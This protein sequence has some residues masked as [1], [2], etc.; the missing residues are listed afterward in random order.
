MSAEAVGYVFRHSP[1]TGAAFQVHL[2]IA[3][4]V[5]DQ[6]ANELWMAT[7]TIAKKAR[8]ARQ[9][10]SEALAEI[11]S[12]GGL[13]VVEDHRRDRAGKPSRYRFLFPVVAVHYESRG[14]TRDDTPPEGV[15]P[16]TTPG[17]SPT[18]TR[19]VTTGDTNPREPKSTTDIGSPNGAKP[20][21]PKKRETQLPK[22]WAPN[23]GHRTRASQLGVGD[24]DHQADQ[25]KYHHEA[26]GSL[27]RSWDAAFHT[28][29][30][31]AP[32]FA[33]SLRAIEGGRD[34]DDP[35]ERLAAYGVTRAREPKA[36]WMN[37]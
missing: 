11:V 32:K 7:G 33:G 23:D 9:T 18:A 16:E 19:G 17:V 31:N 35:D 30:G 28:W 5:N 20:K 34:S 6:H 10:A 21:P 27:F 26:K 4:S 1:H 24:L 2:A 13:E 15:S 36:G 25:F 3:D 14:V 37:G 29:I 8:V 22:G 12:L